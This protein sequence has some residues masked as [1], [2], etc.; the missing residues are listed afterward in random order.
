MDIDKVWTEC[1]ACWSWVIEQL[2][3]SDQRDI[4]SLKDAWIGKHCPQ[5]D[6]LKVNCLFCYS[7]KGNCDDCPG[8]KY[9]ESFNCD[10]DAYSYWWEPR[11]FYAKLLE[12][13][14]IRLKEGK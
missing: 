7:S 5:L 12:L 13:N 4:G 9:D 2:D 11:A 10:N 14:E 8:R 1:I 3:K 6:T